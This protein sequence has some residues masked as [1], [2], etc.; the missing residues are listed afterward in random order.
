M[1]TD[2]KSLTT[3]IKSTLQVSDN[4]LVSITNSF[5]QRFCN[6]NDYLLKQ[7]KISNDYTFLETGFIRSFTFDTEGNEVTTN[8]YGNN[9]IVFEPASFI[10]RKPTTENFQA[11]TDCTTWT[12]KYETFQILFHSIPQFRE[13]AR[14][15]LVNGFITFKERTW[16]MINLTAEQRYENLLNTRPDI[17]QNASL[18]YL[19]SYLGV[20]DTS[21]SRIRKEISQK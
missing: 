3:F 18:K 15:I 8:I 4:I 5:E 7:G 12:L 1:D 14:E 10:K 11:L 6:K 2:K 16:A 21:L 19:A 17:F 9:S 20:T 13:F